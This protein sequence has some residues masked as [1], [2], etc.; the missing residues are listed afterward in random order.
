MLGAEFICEAV[1]VVN[2]LE[3]RDGILDDAVALFVNAA[4]L[5][6]LAIVGAVG[7]DELGDDCH[8]LARVDGF[9]GAVEGGVAGAVGVEV[10]AVAVAE[11]FVLH[12]CVR[13]GIILV[14][15]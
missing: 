4:D 12:C 2:A 9:A 10:A 14:R 3:I 1:G 8:F 11:A 13:I 5:F 7:G 6:E 15:Y